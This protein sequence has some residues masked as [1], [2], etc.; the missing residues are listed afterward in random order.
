MATLPAITAF[1]SMQQL[2]SQPLT[3]NDSKYLLKNL[4]GFFSILHEWSQKTHQPKEDNHHDPP[5]KRTAQASSPKKFRY[6]QFTR[7]IKPTPGALLWLPGLFKV[8][9]YSL[10]VI[11][12]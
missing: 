11:S 12:E 4:S 6:L 10:G 3:P 9:H 7:R 1:Q 2:Y 8:R 5:I